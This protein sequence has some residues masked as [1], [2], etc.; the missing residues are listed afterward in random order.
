MRYAANLLFQYGIDGRHAS[1]PLCEKRIVL[2]DARSPKE[3]LRRA[4]GHG[5]AQQIAYRNADGEQFR[6]R[7]LGLVD[8]IELY[9]E[10]KV[11][12][13]MFR[14]S[15]PEKHLKR[16]E[17]LSVFRPGP[18]TIRSAWWAVP[19]W[20][21][22]R[23]GRER[24]RLRRRWSSPTRTMARFTSAGGPEAHHRGV[25]SPGGKRGDRW[26]RSASELD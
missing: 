14:A 19:K 5:R 13:S 7:Y 22:S 15:R 25:R 20:A 9:G 2:I 26:P 11:Y 24:G 1:R 18:K 21:A 10:D 8:L 16:P 6:I 4:E 17:Q 12:Y 23:V 3:A